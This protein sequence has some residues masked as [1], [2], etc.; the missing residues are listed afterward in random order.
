M[1]PVT[2][3]L[4]V[5]VVVL[6]TQP[7]WAPQWGAGLLGELRLLGPAGAVLAVLAFL[8]LVALYCRTLQRL[9]ERVPPDRRAESPRAVWWMFAVP[10]NFVE[11]F[12]IVRAIG[13]TLRADGRTAPGGVRIW[14]GTGIGWC[15]LQIASLLP[16][17]VGVVTG[18]LALAL[19]GVHWVHT[20][21][22][23]RG[24]R[25]AVPVGA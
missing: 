4:T 17:P 8:V 19:W 2:V 23:D 20:V 15:V 25:A 24:L 16:G 12:F 13:R 6:L 22:I 7:L 9:A 5:P 14:L 11:D 10:F 1:R 18:G 3:V 21:R